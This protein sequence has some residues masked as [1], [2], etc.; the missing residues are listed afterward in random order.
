MARRFFK[1]R[2]KPVEWVR[3]SSESGFTTPYHANLVFDGSTQQ[4][5]NYSNLIIGDEPYATQSLIEERKTYVIDRIVGRLNA[6]ISGRWTVGPS[7]TYSVGGPLLFRWGIFVGETDE[8]GNIQ[9]LDRWDLFTQGGEEV[10]WIHRDSYVIGNNYSVTSPPTNEF[11]WNIAAWFQPDN[12]NLQAP[13][14]MVDTRAKRRV[15]QMERLFIATAVT[16][17]DTQWNYSNYPS[18]L[19]IWSNLRCLL[20]WTAGTNKR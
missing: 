1:R 8:A 2:R 6:Q 9:D 13:W 14:G 10:D 20:H 4:V 15:G 11:P 5:V 18:N 16:A 3:T 12:T 17:A 7:P 19:T